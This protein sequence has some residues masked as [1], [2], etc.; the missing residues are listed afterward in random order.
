[1]P[2]LNTTIDNLELKTNRVFGN[3]PS[4]AWTDEQ[5]PSAKT[6]YSTYNSLHGEC[7]GV[8]D[9]CKTLE[10]NYGT[11][12]KTCESLSD[13]YDTLTES[14][15]KLVNIAHPVGSIM[16]TATNTNPSSKVGG[17]WTL[18]DKGFTS[19]NASSTSYFTP[20]TNVVHN[21]TNVTRAGH[22]IRIRTAVTVNTEVTDT[23]LSLGTLNFSSFGITKIATGLVGGTVFSDGANCGISWNLDAATGE[24]SISDV[25]ETAK[26]TSGNGF[27]I[28]MTFPVQYTHMVDSFCDKFYW[29]RTA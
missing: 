23:G 6:L 19:A 18:I 21:D 9:R 24:L 7:T 26:T 8:S 27:N 2:K 12:T 10:T 1:M 28:D 29:K 3:T 15:N 25:F 16:I 5:Y 13:S 17:T 11:L 22:T 4:A 14:Y 20:K